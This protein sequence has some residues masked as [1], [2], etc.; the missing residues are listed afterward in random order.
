MLD[1][2]KHKFILIQILKDIYSD[3]GLAPILGFKGGTACYLFYGLPRFSVDLDFNL[4]ETEK[5]NLVFE[6]IKR[7]LK[8]YGTI[9]Q[10]FKKRFTL[11]FLLSYDKE[12]RNIKIEISKRKF[13]EHYEVKNYLGIPMKV[14]KKEDI[15]AHKLVALLERKNI[16]NRD[17][18]DIYYFMKRNWPIN[19]EL[20]ELRTKL[21]FKK[22]FQK[23]QRAIEKVDERYILQGLGEILDEKQKKWTKEN[24][25][26]EL[27]FLFKLYLEQSK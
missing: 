17:L 14:M 13:P 8:N 18:F 3:S 26:K 9:K 25:K 23:C 10:A 19:K 11:F 5:E 16:A 2:Q 12:E 4:L 27:L 22:Y 15:F 7:I 24:L 21:K 20:V 1:I 6:K